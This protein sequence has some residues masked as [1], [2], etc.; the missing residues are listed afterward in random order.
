[1]GIMGKIITNDDDNNENIKKQK[2]LKFSY[3]K[4]YIYW[5]LDILWI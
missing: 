3:I 1:M 5:I 2:G 4:K